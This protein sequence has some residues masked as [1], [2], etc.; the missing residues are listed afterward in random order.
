MV[1]VVETVRSATSL[2]DSDMATLIANEEVAS[3]AASAAQ[4]ALGRG[5]RPTRRADA[6]LVG[7]VKR[8]V[9]GD[10]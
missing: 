2:P 9:L 4:A 10:P 5:A 7:R 3:K 8:G 1:P 6:L